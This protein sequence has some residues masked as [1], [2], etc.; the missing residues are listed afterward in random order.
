M[1]ADGLTVRD[2]CVSARRGQESIAIASDMS[3]SVAPGEAIA[4]VG[5]SGSGKSLTARA[6]MGLLP[7]GVTASGEADFVGRDLLT[8]SAADLRRLRGREMALVMQDPFTMLNP[9]ERCGVQIV[10]ALASGRGDRLSRKE[11]R[12][13]AGE[14]LREVGIDDPAVADRYPF[15]LSGGMRQRVGIA[16]AIAEQPRLLIADEPT[17]ALDV[18]I[19][20]EIL[21]LLGSLRSAHSMGLILITHDLR[22]AFSVCD[23][24]YVMYA[25]SLVEVAPTPLLARAPRHPYSL[26]LLLADPPS[27]R[28]VEELVGI[29]GSVPSP[30]S[31]PPGCPFAPRCDYRIGACTASL[32]P[33][34]EVGADQFARCIRAD[35]LRVELGTRLAAAQGGEQ[36][37][38]ATLATPLEGEPLVVAEHVRKVF[39]G[40]GG[41]DVVALDDVSV[42]VA[43]GE[44]VGLVGESGSGKTTLGRV[45]V[46]LEQATAGSVR[47]GGVELVGTAVRRR[48]AAAVR[49]VVQMVFQDP[50]STLN[51]AR[52]VGATL[53]EAAAL[54]PGGMTQSSGEL[55]EHVGLPASYAARRPAQLSGGE[56]QRVAI[57]RTL[58]R[59]P[60][61]IVCDEVVSALDVSVQAQILNLLRRLRD[62]L[63]L[64]YLF[65]T[66][67]LAVVRQITDRIYVLQRGELVEEGPTATVLDAPSHPYTRRLVASVPEHPQSGAIGS[68]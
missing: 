61:L 36:G 28:R 8:L 3:F 10:E 63:G 35:E 12:R 18:T 27:D 40:R 37:G 13:I 16:A 49:D 20:R 23:R 57:A 2:L 42:Q 30:G 65:I 67:D 29:A 15:E 39:G 52:T 14:R 41:S 46:Q 56:R 11:R 1:S 53:K 43:A 32:P 25:G 48:D 17:T 9:L 22:V 54:A 45:L 59:R 62:E 38:E 50:Y 6:V 66:H 55:L 4:I 34:A 21:E 26:G 64:A 7:E 31:R 24:A 60:R 51:P 33:L 44:S 5:E 47:V 19:Q 68:R 58:A